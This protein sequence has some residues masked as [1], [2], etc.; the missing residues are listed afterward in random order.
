MNSDQISTTAN[1]LVTAALGA[2]TL[3]GI[4]TGS[5]AQQLAAVGAL[6]I[7]A[8]VTI[9]TGLGTI[10]SIALAV[11]RRNHTAQGQAAGRSVAAQPTVAQALDTAAPVLNALRDQ[12][13]VV[14]VTVGKT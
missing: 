10:A 4:V 1:Q 9:I 6:V 7:P 13:V 11:W 2:L 14:G 3:L 8:A 5:E 12:G